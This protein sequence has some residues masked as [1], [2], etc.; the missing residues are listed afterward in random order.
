[1]AWFQKDK[2]TTTARV[3][4]PVD[5]PSG[6][7]VET[8]SGVYYIKGKTKYKVFSDRVLDSWN[9]GMILPGSAASVSKFNYGGPL[10]FRDG[11]LI[12]NIADGKIYLVSANKRR[13]I[14]SPEAFSRFGMD[15]SKTMEVSQAEINLHEEG[16]PL[17]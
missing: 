13:H 17:Q 15:R 1:M 8:E 2:P 16:E 12:K 9:F 10:G 11:S 3:L 14:Q 6:S 7:A 4:S 5:Y